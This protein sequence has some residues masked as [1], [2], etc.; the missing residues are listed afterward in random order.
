MIPYDY[1]V[2]FG[3]LFVDEDGSVVDLERSTQHLTKLHEF[4]SSRLKEG[5]KSEGVSMVY[6]TKIMVSDPSQGYMLVEG[7]DSF[8]KVSLDLQLYYSQDQE[9]LEVAYFRDNLN[10]YIKQ[11]IGD[12][13]PLGELEFEGLVWP[14]PNNVSGYL[15]AV[16]GYI[17]TPAKYNKETRKYEKM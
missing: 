6:S 13:L 7:C 16:Y 11:N 8:P 3:V 17:G 1:D 4:I 10:Q 14:C 2:D 12:A 9:T 15:E 5:Y